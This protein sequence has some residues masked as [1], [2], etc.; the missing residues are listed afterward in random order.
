MALPNLI[1]SP[2]KKMPENILKAQLREVLCIR[3]CWIQIWCKHGP[4]L[5]KYKIALVELRIISSCYSVALTVQFSS[6][7]NDN[8]LSGSPEHI[9]HS[10]CFSCISIDVAI[11]KC[12]LTVIICSPVQLKRPARVVA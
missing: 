9:I 12:A 10:L 7:V 4:D 1:L 5:S 2:G 8:Q 3:V 6:K 11:I